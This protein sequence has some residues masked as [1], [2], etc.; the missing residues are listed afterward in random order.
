MWLYSYLS[1]CWSDLSSYSRQPK[2]PTRLR[3]LLRSPFKVGPSSLSNFQSFPRVRSL[4]PR[5]ELLLLSLY[6]L[7]QTASLFKNILGSLS[8]GRKNYKKNIIKMVTYRRKE[9]YYVFS[10]GLGWW[11]LVCS[12][13]CLWL[14]YFFLH[15]ILFC[16]SRICY[17]P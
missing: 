13:L 17:P 3:W 16:S 15:C 2:S 11:H 8:K 1:L 10:V 7:I 12:L 6:C 9:K 14:Y 4:L 5:K